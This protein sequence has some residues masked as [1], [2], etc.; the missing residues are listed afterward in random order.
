MKPIQVHRINAKHK[1]NVK[2]GKSFNFREQNVSSKEDFSSI[3]PF[4]ISGR[5][6]HTIRLN[7][8]MVLSTSRN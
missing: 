2:G 7:I 4:L 5:H 3:M 6:F 8:E 1:D